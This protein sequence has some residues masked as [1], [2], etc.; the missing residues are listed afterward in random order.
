MTYREVSFTIPAL[1]WRASWQ[2]HVNDVGL[3]LTYWPPFGVTLTI[4]IHSITLGADGGY[5]YYG[6]A[7]SWFPKE[8][9]LHFSV[10]STRGWWL[11]L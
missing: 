5:K 9:S 7:L 4:G 6:P 2:K 1:T 3:A 10:S 8:Q 11:W